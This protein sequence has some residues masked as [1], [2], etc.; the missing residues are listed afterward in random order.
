M[1]GRPRSYD[2]DARSLAA[3][4]VPVACRRPTDGRGEA[5]RRNLLLFFS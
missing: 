3:S 4:G 5:F 2:A 1:R